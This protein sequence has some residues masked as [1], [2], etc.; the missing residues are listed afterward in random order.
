MNRVFV[1]KL[2]NKIYLM[3]KDIYDYTTFAPNENA[4]GEIIYNS[5]KKV[6]EKGFPLSQIFTS[7]I[8]TNEINILE[9]ET[10]F[11]LL[12]II[13]KSKEKQ[14]LILFI[15]NPDIIV[16]AKKIEILYYHL[17]KEN[18]V[19]IKYII[20]RKIIDINNLNTVIS[21]KFM[22][23]FIGIPLINYVEILFTNTDN[24]NIQYRVFPFFVYV[25][26]D[27]FINHFINSIYNLFIE[28]VNYPYKTYSEKSVA[29]GI[30]TQDILFLNKF[31]SENSNNVI[32]N[33]N[34]KFIRN[35]L[36]TNTNI[37]IEFIYL[38]QI[39][40]E[41]TTNEIKTNYIEL[42]FRNTSYS[43]TT[44]ANEITPS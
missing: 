19:Y 33:V 10:D 35:L 7:N 36:R 6:N 1:V 16:N 43:S 42:K 5:I 15:L 22:K 26:N 8:I 39:I 2:K 25:E 37:A 28:R 21:T 32:G 4:I 12:N 14:N 40:E 27:D 20:N 38:S 41:T 18:L 24:N 30:I 11:F 13:N 23:N 17:V 9:K 3:K 34:R 31:Y 29:Y 44:I